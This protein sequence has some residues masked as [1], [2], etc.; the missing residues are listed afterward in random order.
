MSDSDNDHAHAQPVL[1]A[2]V[3]DISYLT[4]LLRGVSFANRATITATG[5]GFTV[6]VEEARTLLATA[7]IF[8]DIF[9]EYAYHSEAAPS[10][11]SQDDGV[12]NMAFEIPL[13]TLIECLNIFGTAGAHPSSTTLGGKRWKKQEEDKGSDEEE[14]EGEGANNKRRGI[15]QYFGAGPEKSTGMRLTYE[16]A[17]FPLTLLIAEDADGPTTACEIVTYDPE[18]H[19]DLQFKPDEMILKIILKSSWLRDALS[20]LDPSCDKLTF[21]GNPPPDGVPPATSG[22]PSRNAEVSRGTS[23]S[24]PMLRIHADGAFGSTEM[25]YPNDRDVLETFECEQNVCF[26]YRTSHITRAIR[27]LQNS[28]KTSLRIDSEGLMSM[29]FLMP[30]PSFKSRAGADAFIEFRCLPLEEAL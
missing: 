28:T 4:T 7:Y 1:R 30:S 12:D 18:P 8:A 5:S 29:Q 2:S 13:N 10:Q 25:D 24:K 21:I 9:D 22:R 11:Q 23:T 26:S 17:G 14:G 6:T 16:G 20:E 15:A 27:A 19:L 3:H